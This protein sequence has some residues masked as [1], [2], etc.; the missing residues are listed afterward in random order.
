MRFVNNNLVFCLFSLSLLCSC[1]NNSF[2]QEKASEEA[3]MSQM[4]VGEVVSQESLSGVLV[5]D[6]SE[7]EAIDN[8]SA[9]VS[10]STPSSTM[11]LSPIPNHIIAQTGSVIKDDGIHKIIYT[12]QLKFKVTN[13]AEVTYAIEN[14]ARNNKGHI[15]RSSM[16]NNS[17]AKVIRLSKDSS[18]MINY[19]NLVSTIEFTVPKENFSSTLSEIAPL[20]SVIDYRNINGQDVTFDLVAAEL[21]RMRNIEKGSR[22]KNAVSSSGHRLGDVTTAEHVIDIAK[23]Q[24]DEARLKDLRLQDQIDYSSISIFLYQDQT[25]TIG[26]IANSLSIEEYGQSFGSRLVDAIDN[27]WSGVCMCFVFIMNIWPI[28]LVGILVFVL[29]SYLRKQKNK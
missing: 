7:G 18:L 21:E 20:A 24:A 16:N 6:I 1:G 15:I 8:R 5:K 3:A 27:G 10:K 25:E 11:S 17:S 2:R 26:H 19:N 28:I 14:I 4:P 29:Y 23:A 22:M 9:I 13:V 12:T